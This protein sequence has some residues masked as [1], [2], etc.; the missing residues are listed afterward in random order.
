MRAHDQKRTLLV[1]LLSPMTAH[2]K[3]TAQKRHFGAFLTQGQLLSP[4][5]PAGS[6]QGSRTAR[7]PTLELIMTPEARVRVL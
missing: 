2:A 6:L 4:H 7:A 3:K 1:L 5:D